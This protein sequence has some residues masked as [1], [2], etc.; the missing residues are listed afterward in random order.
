MHYGFEPLGSFTCGNMPMSG[1]K[2]GST[3]NSTN[4]LVQ[5][6]NPA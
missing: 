3:A 4:S 1:T 5:S 2:T 6:L